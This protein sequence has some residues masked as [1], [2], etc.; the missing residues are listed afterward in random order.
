MKDLQWWKSKAIELANAINELE[1][2]ELFPIAIQHS[3]EKNV[4]EVLLNDK[5]ERELSNLSW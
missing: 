1:S 2:P 3:V 5:L 4:D